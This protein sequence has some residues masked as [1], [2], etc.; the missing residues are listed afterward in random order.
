MTLWSKTTPGLTIR[1]LPRLRLKPCGKQW[2]TAVRMT[3]GTGG[4]SGKSAQ[5]K[6]RSSNAT[7]AVLVSGGLDSSIL[8]ADLLRRVAGAKR[9]VPQ[10]RVQPIYVRSGL[11][12]ETAELRAV[13]RFL[14]TLG[15]DQP[16]LMGLV[17]LDLPVADI[18]AIHWSVTGRDAPGAESPD[19]A[20]YLP[21]RNLLL[22]VKAALWCRMHGV[23]ELAL[24]VL[25][26]N[27][28][29]DATP[30]FFADFQGSL[31]HAVGGRLRIARPF[32]SLTK[33]EVMERGAGLPLGLTFSC[34]A[35]VRGLHCGQC[36]KC[37][38]RRAAFRSV[39][40]TDPTRYTADC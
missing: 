14:M 7:V 5:M 17:V 15:P 19:E 3:S 26:S 11:F 29:A 24:G 18:Y 22:L 34:L 21:G 40:Q 28:F 23:D 37:A 8:L 25:G 32:A 33:R 20:V 38:E 35:P 16:G 39:G 6:S 30:A 36:N 13:K 31:N 2:H 4:S 10:R 9:S 1:S 27:P 12:W